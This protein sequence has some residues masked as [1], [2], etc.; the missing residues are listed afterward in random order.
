M[1]QEFYRLSNRAMI[2]AMSIAQ[3]RP[4]TILEF[5]AWEELQEPRYEFDGVQPLAMA[6]GG[7]AHEAIG[8]TPRALLRERL[9]GKPCR[10]RGPTLKVEVAGRIRHPDAFVYRGPVR[11]SETVIRD[12]GV[13]FEV[14]SPSTSHTD[15]IIKLREYQATPSIRRYVI[16]EQGS[17][18]ATVLT[19]R[20]DEWLARA[21]TE[22]DVL[23][24][25]EIDVALGLAEIHA[26]VELPTA[27][28]TKRHDGG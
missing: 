7:D 22:D 1:L 24:M 18:A 8:G 2:W 5:L 12:P 15:R 20:G 11:G 21:L 14:V 13:V 16:I 10:V 3:R 23:E 9:L 6:G 25:P 4:M 17:I 19:R 27:D 26:D 28:M